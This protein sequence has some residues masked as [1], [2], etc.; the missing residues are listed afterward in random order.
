MIGV[1]R[2]GHTNCHNNPK[3]F[4]FRFFF[5]SP[6][7]LG[8]GKIC[9]LRGSMETHTTQR[10][11]AGSAALKARFSARGLAPGKHRWRAP[12]HQEISKK[13]TGHRGMDQNTPIFQ[14]LKQRKVGPKGPPYKDLMHNHSPLMRWVCEL[15]VSSFPLINRYP[16]KNWLVYWGSQFKDYKHPDL[17][18]II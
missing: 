12:S 2:V 10:G 15:Q 16:M 6:A 1:S 4:A 11:A 17:S 8:Y 5:Q 3:N 7:S 14:S 9:P 18:P 13:H